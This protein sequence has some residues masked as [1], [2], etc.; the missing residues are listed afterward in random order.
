MSQITLETALKFRLH[1][2]ADKRHGSLHYC[3]SETG[4]HV[5]ADAYINKRESGKTS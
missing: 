2:D 5:R 4:A 1:R 3:T